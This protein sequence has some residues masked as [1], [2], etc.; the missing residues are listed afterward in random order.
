MDERQ[1]WQDSR[2]AC[3]PGTMWGTAPR[4]NLQ[5]VHGAVLTRQLWQAA[6]APSSRLSGTIPARTR[7]GLSPTT[8]AIGHHTPRPRRQAMLAAGYA[9]ILTAA[10][11]PASWR[12]L[13]QY[14]AC[15]RGFK[16]GR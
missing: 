16:V 11:T 6:V 1:R 3:V 7:I 4:Q 10:D 5:V 15:V 8:R 13:V 14:R 9:R 12:K 2:P